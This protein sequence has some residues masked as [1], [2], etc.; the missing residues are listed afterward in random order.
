[1]KPEN[2]LLD[3]KG[4]VKLT[5]FGLSKILENE[6][7]K[8]FTICGT[9]QYSAP[10]ILIKK[11]YDKSIDWWSLGCFIYEML[12]GFLPFYIPKGNK[13]NPKFRS[14][15]SGFYEPHD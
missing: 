11:G 1:M 10:E 15:K 5:D 2:I 14:K 13:I 8:A 12:T 6:E 4:H 7:D 9:P 3:S